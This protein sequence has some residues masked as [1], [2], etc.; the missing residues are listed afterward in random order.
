MKITYEFDTQAD[1][2]D[3][4]ELYNVQHATDTFCAL[5][6]IKNYLREQWK[7]KEVPDDI[8]KIYER[9]FEIINENGLEL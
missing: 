3:E 9:F 4:F 8:D 5:E 2:F 1:N 6:D 7:Y